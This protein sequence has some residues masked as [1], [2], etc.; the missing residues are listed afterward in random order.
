MAKPKTK[1]ISIK[2]PESM[3]NDLLKMAVKENTKRWI[4]WS[5]KKVHTKG[6]TD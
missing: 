4:I 2:L 3:Y 1:A 5:N 6:I